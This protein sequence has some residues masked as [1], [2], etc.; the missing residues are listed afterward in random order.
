VSMSPL[1]RWAKRH[2][3]F[4]AKGPAPSSKGTTIKTAASV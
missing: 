1:L 2:M 4:R 3:G